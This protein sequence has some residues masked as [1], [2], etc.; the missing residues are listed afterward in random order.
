MHSSVVATC[1]DHHDAAALLKTRRRLGP[2]MVSRQLVESQAYIHQEHELVNR[3]VS[4]L[5]PGYPTSFEGKIIHYNAGLCPEY[6]FHVTYSNT[7]MATR[8][9]SLKP[10]TL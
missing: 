10:S 4:K 6:P 7:T 3:F 8:K 9:T 5:F 2:V 1:F